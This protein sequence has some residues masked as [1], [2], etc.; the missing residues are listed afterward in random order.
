VTSVTV[1][2]AIETSGLSKRF[3]GVTALDDVNL[4]VPRGAVLALLGRNGAGK[5]TLLQILLG[6]QQPSAGRARV[7]GHDPV[8]AGPLVRAR[9]GYV[10]E[11]LPIYDWMTVAEAI[12]FT[13]SFYPNWDEALAETLLQRFD[14]PRRRRVG[15]LSR[16]MRAQLNLVL[17]LAYRPEVLLLDECTAGLDVV[18]RRDF[19]E[20]IIETAADAGRTVLFASHQVVELERLCDWIGIL[21]GGRLLVQ[22][23][24]E[25]LRARVRRLHLAF[26]GR[27]QDLRR[28]GVLA[29]ERGRREVAVTVSDYSEALLA[30]YAAAGA[31]VEVED[32]RLDEILVAFVGAGGRDDEPVGAGPAL[33]R[34]A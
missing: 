30:R 13:R 29:V 24:L 21:E 15:R 20:R 26:T 33:E 25:A 28:P 2:A 11:R 14:L 10:P 5:S 9:T 4:R 34:V 12:R 19:T 7:A 17:S 6:L 18:I 27:E 22:E 32:L 3:A 23:P 1:A 8:T 16:G 31:A